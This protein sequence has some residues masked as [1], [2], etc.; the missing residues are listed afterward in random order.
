MPVSYRNAEDT[1]LISGTDKCILLNAGDQ[2]NL[3]SCYVCQ[4]IWKSLT[5]TQG[6][7]ST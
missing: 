7:I 5:Q 3:S 6:N 4:G 2:S 1:S